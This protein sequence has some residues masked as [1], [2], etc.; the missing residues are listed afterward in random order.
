MTA[1]SDTILWQPVIVLPST[2]KATLNFTLGGAPGGY[3]VVVAGHTLD[4]RVGAVR[5]VIP[6]APAEPANATNTTGQSESV[7]PVTPGS[8]PA[9]PAPDKR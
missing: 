9:P 7:P 2:G 4:G 5:G 1:E 6:V 3:Q 8:Q